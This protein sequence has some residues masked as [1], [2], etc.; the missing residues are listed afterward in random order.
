[1]F[2][3]CYPRWSEWPTI[4]DCRQWRDI[5]ATLKLYSKI[6]LPL[7]DRIKN[8][9]SPN[10]SRR[11]PTLHR[12]DVNRWIGTLVCACVRWQRTVYCTELVLN[13]FENRFLLLSFLTLGQNH[14]KTSSHESMQQAISTQTKRLIL[15]KC[16][17][18]IGSVD[19]PMLFMCVKWTLW[20]LSSDRNHETFY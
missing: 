7:L 12:C 5:D 6:Q 4:L 11:R 8:D 17:T 16:I 10:A 15:W 20:V 3:V 2:T 13:Y 14:R 19:V 9:M 1:M 18:P